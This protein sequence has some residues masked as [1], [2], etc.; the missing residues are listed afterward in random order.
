MYLVSEEEDIGERSGY[1]RVGTTEIEN[2]RLLICKRY[3]C[4]FIRYD[5]GVDVSSFAIS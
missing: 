3:Q 2:G 1:I 4:F 5:E